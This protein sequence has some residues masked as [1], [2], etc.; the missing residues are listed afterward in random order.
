M[1]P[2]WY[3]QSSTPLANGTDIGH[4]IVL[5]LLGVVATAVAVWGFQRRELA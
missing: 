5:A 3:Y 1:S 4:V 2:W